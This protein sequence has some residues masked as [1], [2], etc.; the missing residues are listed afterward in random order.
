MS[1]TKEMGEN[2]CRAVRRPDSPHQRAG[3]LGRR[4]DRR[5]GGGR[6]AF[7]DFW[8]VLDDWIG[9]FFENADHN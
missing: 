9:I 2:V 5:G 7:V 4:G 8:P 6:S 3:G 1:A